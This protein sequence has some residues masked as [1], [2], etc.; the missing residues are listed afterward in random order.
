MRGLF[1]CASLDAT[2]LIVMERVAI[3]GP[4]LNCFLRVISGHEAQHFEG[5]P[6]VKG[7]RSNLRGAT[8][9]PVSCQSLSV[10]R[11]SELENRAPDQD[12]RKKR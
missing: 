10:I 9:G 5:F 8:S 11:C 1:R 2:P 3:H 7:S 12:E 6:R 4:F